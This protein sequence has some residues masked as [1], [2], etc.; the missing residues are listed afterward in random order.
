MEG[1]YAILSTCTL[2]QWAMDFQGNK[3]RIIKSIHQAKLNNAA[4]RVG[5]E[6]EITGYG[7]EDHFLEL[8]TIQHSWEVLIEIIESGVGK[9]ILLDLGMPVEH[10]GIIYNCR[11]IVFNTNI[12]LIRP[13]IAMADDGNYRE[14][15]W[16][17]PWKKGYIL[18]TFILPRMFSEKFNQT[19]CKIGIGI[20]QAKDLSYAPEICE[21]LWIPHSPSTDFAMWGVDIIGNSSGSHFMI[22]KQERRYE[23]IVNSSKKNGGVYIYSNLIGCDGG[24]LYFDGGSFISMNGKVLTEGKRFSL[25][26]VEVVVTK[27]DLN[28]V[29]SYRLSLKSRCIQSSEVVTNIPI[30]TLSAELCTGNTYNYDPF[31]KIQPKQYTYEEEMMLAAPCWL[32]D[33]LRRSGGSG[34]FLA[35]SGGADSSCVCLMVS[36]MTRLIYDCIAENKNEL[37]QNE[38][39]KDLR[40]VLG[41]NDY[42]PK[43]AKE[44]ANMLLVTCYMGTKFSSEKT[45][46]NAK[47]LAE[48]C[49]AYHLDIDIDDIFS[50][51]KSVVEVALKKEIKFQS[52]SGGYSEDLALQNIQARIR[53]CLSYMLAGLV[54]WSVERKGFLLVLASGNLDE[55]MMGYLTKYDCSSADVNPIGSVSKIRLRKFLEYSYKN[56]DYKSL[57]GVLEIEPSAELRP[58]VEGKKGQTDED[59]MGITYEELSIMGQLRKDY[60]C[61]PCAMY[62]RLGQIWK[63]KKPSEIVDKVKLFFKRYSTNRHKMTTITPSLFVESYSNDDN[64]YDLRQ[65]LYNTTWE[66]Q[67]NKIDKG[68]HKINLN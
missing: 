11:I 8:D 64:R 47:V 66:F 42:I 41:K 6:L 65:F 1:R 43:S 62:M 21:E 61:G 25:N 10:K 13:K 68:A 34:Y 46:T 9:D 54:N 60:R 27:V 52:E 29:E 26:E 50:S 49:E 30:I 32:W 18:E 2:N 31:N 16:F 63:N 55:G 37:E 7:C 38:V 48:E 17:T 36:L 20:I 24:R 33:Y 28:E 39:L 22:N 19:E 67:F 44:I 3:N 14:N 57:K 15:R 35:L 58:F 40:R 12:L 56:L 4:I 53:M 23:L 5:P 51:F 59:D 45:K